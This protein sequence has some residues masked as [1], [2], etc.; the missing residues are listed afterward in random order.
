MRR[1]DY[2]QRSITQ[3]AHTLH[4]ILRLIDDRRPA[5]A[6]DAI[7]EAT[8]RLLGLRFRTLTDLSDS[9]LLTRLTFGESA[10][11][12]RDTCLFLAALL[13]IA[14]GLY[15]DENQLDE[16]YA[17]T[18]RALTLVL[19][20]LPRD[21][22]SALPAYA[23]DIDRLLAD[24]SAYELPA[25][26]MLRLQEHYERIGDYAKAEDTLFTLLAA[27]PA[28]T[29]LL[30]RGIAFY[31]RLLQHDDATLCAGNLPRDEVEAALAELR[32]R[33]T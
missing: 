31:Q 4:H 27:A 16:S 32:A 10:R 26:T 15:A 19:E 11:A 8:Q 6:L 3:F 13:N 25:T 23:P 33:H 7:G 17:C 12:G 20:A 9:D 18:L 5:A 2:L 22:T 28:N 24:L 14:A 29:N 1:E 21:T 30:A